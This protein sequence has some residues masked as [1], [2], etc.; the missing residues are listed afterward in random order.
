M[1]FKPKRF[2]RGKLER[3]PLASGVTAT[4]WSLLKTSSGYFTNAAGADNTVE[5]IARETVTDATSSDGG[6]WCDVI[7]IDDEMEID[8]TC[9]ATPVQATHVGNN[10]DLTDAATVNLAGT[11]D[12]VFYIRKIMD[13]TNK[14]VRGNFNRHAIQ[15]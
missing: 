8:A 6:T 12:L 1:S 14:I 9:S 11:T 5:V 10:Y 13:S 3:V 15:S 7:I 4:K 2:D